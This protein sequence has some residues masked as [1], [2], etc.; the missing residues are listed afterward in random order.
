MYSNYFPPQY[1]GAAK[2]AL[3]LAKCLRVRGHHVE[4]ITVQ[5]PGLA[6]EE[7][8]EDFPVHRVEMGRGSRHKE[9]RLWW[10]LFRFTLRHRRNFDILH[11]HG[12]YY[13]NAI[14]GPLAKLLGWR[15]LVKA[16]LADDDLHGIN[17]TLAG[18]IHYRFLS[19]VDACVAISLDLQKEF[20]AAGLSAGKV[21]L[22]ANGVDTTR[23][24]PAAASEKQALRKT[25]G[26]PGHRP[27]VLSVGVFDRRKNIG[28]LIDE[29]LRQ[30]GFSTGAFL[31]AI[32]PQSREDSDGAFL[33]SLQRFAAEHPESLGIIGHVA[34]IEDYYRAAD[35]FVLPSSSEGMPNVVLEAMASG[36]PCVATDVSGSRELIQDGATGFLFEP[37]DA[38]SLRRCLLRVLDG[39]A[40]RMG[41]AG[42]SLVENNYSITAL[43]EKYERLYEQLLTSGQ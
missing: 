39:A 29:W 36:L 38:A 26:L 23:F 7:T 34:N 18:R 8:C 32:G 33:G 43:A 41:Q 37:G 9:F 10:N 27:L 20:L 28:W 14:V 11:S 24:Y 17:R 40:E 13:T 30:A 3:A 35:L 25:L 6:K 1:S 31:L 21:H 19:M 16:S 15:T 12:A 2:Q 42:R 22:L 4:F 5:W